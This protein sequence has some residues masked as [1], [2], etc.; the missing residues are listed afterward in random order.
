MSSK[1][2]A[3]KDKCKITKIRTMNSYKSH[4]KAKTIYNQSFELVF[5]R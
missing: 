4:I 5:K 2:V 3:K 1:E